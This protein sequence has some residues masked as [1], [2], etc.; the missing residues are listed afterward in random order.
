KKISLKKVGKWVPLCCTLEGGVDLG[1]GLEYLTLDININNFMN[2]ELQNNLQIFMILTTQKKSKYFENQITKTYEEFCTKFSKLSYKRKIF[3]DF[4]TTK[5]LANF[6]NFD[7]F[8]QLIRNL[9]LNFQDFLVSQNIFI[10][11]KK[12]P[13]FRNFFLFFSIFLKT[14]GKCFFHRKPPP[15]FEIEALFRLVMLRQVGTAL[16]HI[17]GWGEP[18][19]RVG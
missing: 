13:F 10:Q 14:V 3:Y 5:L 19:T 11:N 17:R 12:F 15:K 9:V 2:F 16:L 8:Q 18:R 1:L 4:P 6:R 7:I